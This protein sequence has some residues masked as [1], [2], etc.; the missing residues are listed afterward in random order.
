MKALAAFLGIAAIALVEY[1]SYHPHAHNFH[2]GI[3][4]G[5]ISVA[6]SFFFLGRMTKI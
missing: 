6:A 3:T 1:G 5:I 4:G 2:L